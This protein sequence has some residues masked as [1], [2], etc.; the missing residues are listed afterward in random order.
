MNIKQYLQGVPE[1]DQLYIKEKVV[2]FLTIYNSDNF[3]DYLAFRIVE[4]I[5]EKDMREKGGMEE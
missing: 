1:Q 4:I 5:I 3:N 2:E